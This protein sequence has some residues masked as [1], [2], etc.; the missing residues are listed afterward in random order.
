MERRAFGRSMTGLWSGVPVPAPAG[1]S[2]S[3]RSRSRTSS[4]PGVPMACLG[5]G[6]AIC[7]TVLDST[8]P[9]IMGPLARFSDT[10]HLS[11][12]REFLEP[13]TCFFSS[14]ISS[15]SRILLSY[16]K[17]S[18]L[19]CFSVCWHRAATQTRATTVSRASVRAALGVR[20]FALFCFR[21]PSESDRGTVAIRVHL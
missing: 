21:R 6:L 4:P 11:C 14:P 16:H 17:A 18:F 1:R 7:R 20:S 13:S 10:L 5:G 9:V 12:G 2:S 8:S 19:N 15:P 3:W